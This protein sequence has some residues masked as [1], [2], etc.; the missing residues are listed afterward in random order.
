MIEMDQSRK[1]SIVMEDGQ[2]LRLV[3]RASEDRS[4]KNSSVTATQRRL[5]L[6]ALP[7]I[8]T[9]HSCEAGFARTTALSSSP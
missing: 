8:P 6:G 5:A 1:S 7:M 3:Q 9:H 2:Q 4:Y